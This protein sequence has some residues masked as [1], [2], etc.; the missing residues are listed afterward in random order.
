MSKLK[1][2]V[3]G[4]GYIGLPTAAIISK[5]KIMTYGFDINKSIVNTINKGNIHITEPKLDKIVSKSVS[6]GYLKASTKIKK[7]NI[8]IITVPTPLKEENLPDISYIMNA[9]SSIA[10]HLHKGNLIILESTSPI[11]TTRLLSEKLKALRPDLIF[12]HEDSDVQDINICYCPERV[13]PGNT[14]NELISNDRVIG[15]ITKECSDKAADFYKK[16]VKGDCYETSAETAELSKLA[17]NSFRDLNIAFANEISMICSEKN[18]NVWELITIANK[19]PRVNILQPGPGVGGHC[20]AVD[21][22][23]IVS[24]SKNAK[25][26]KKA[27]EINIQ[28]T[29]F[30]FNEIKSSVT[31]I[32]KELSIKTANI[33]IALF[34][35][36]FK[37]D[38]DD[39]R[40]SPAIDIVNQ[41]IKKLDSNILI[42]EPNISK[43]PDIFRDSAKLCSVK[44]ATE[45]CHLAVCLVDHKEFKSLRK[46]DFKNKMIIDS[47]GIW[48]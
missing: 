32:K 38:I 22:W 33:N 29:R 46:N 30:I 26:I 3:I 45:N 6:S 7:S 11:G 15:G 5:R 25:L 44:Y 17:E 48:K 37:A 24:S 4:L 10:S 13:I 16:F 19:H 8:F 35:L 34:G 21:P 39:L 9:A 23:F 43:L 14:I 31:E 40:E 2:T 42:V 18:I 27:R 41:V 1:V 28:K 36:A 12:P 47:K 20:I